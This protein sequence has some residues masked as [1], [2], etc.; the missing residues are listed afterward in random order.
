MNK[1]CN[2]REQSARLAFIYA[3]SSHVAVSTVRSCAVQKG[4][5]RSDQK[6][7]ITPGMTNLR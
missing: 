7:L 2:L 3:P 1:A 5:S 6:V 4:K